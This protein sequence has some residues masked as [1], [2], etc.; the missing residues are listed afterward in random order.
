MWELSSVIRSNYK[1]HQIYVDF[2]YVFTSEKLVM[3]IIIIIIIIIYFNWKWVLTRG[4]GITIRHNIQITHD[5]QK[6][7]HNVK[8][9][10][11]HALN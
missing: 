6:K 2:Y 3:W 11:V 7:L 4:S 9:K 8:G 10:I 5:A 1:K